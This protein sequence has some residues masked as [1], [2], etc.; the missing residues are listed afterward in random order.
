MNY[1]DLG[2]I[3]SFTPSFSVLNYN[4]YNPY[5]HNNIS[6]TTINQKQKDGDQNAVAT[7]IRLLNAA[8]KSVFIL[9]QDGEEVAIISNA[10][11]NN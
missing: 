6:M 4:S 2:M 7:F 9:R 8:E 11:V 5:P 3:C 1:T 10:E